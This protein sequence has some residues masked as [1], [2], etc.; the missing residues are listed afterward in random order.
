MPGRLSHRGGDR[1]PRGAAG[2]LPAYVTVDHVSGRTTV[3]VHT[4]GAGYVTHEMLLAR[5]TGG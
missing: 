1:V 5:V 3:G 4:K 2:A